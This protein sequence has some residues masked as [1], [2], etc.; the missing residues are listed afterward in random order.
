M[1][2]ILNAIFATAMLAPT[3]A[4]ASPIF[5][6]G[7]FETPQNPSGVYEVSSID[8]WTLT[9]AHV[10]SSAELNTAHGGSTTAADGQQFATLNANGS[11]GSVAQTFDTV[12]GKHYLVSFAQNQF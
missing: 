3:V 4:Q 11:I 12:A 1:K 9:N 2:R 7:S 5:S 8:A 10:T 6:N